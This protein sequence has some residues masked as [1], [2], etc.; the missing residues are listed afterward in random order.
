MDSACTVEDTVTIFKTVHNECMYQGSCC[1]DS[2][3]TRYCSRLTKCI[4]Q[5]LENRLTCLSNLNSLWMTTPRQMTS[6][7]SGMCRPSKLMK[8]Q[9]VLASCCRDPTSKED[10]MCTVS[11]I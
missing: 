2:Q 8:P 3:C 4:K 10:K 5:R 1:V 7:D 9:L 6:V 11:N